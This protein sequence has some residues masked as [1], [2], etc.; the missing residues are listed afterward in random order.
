MNGKVGR[1]K[2]V[3]EG[4]ITVHLEPPCGGTWLKPERMQI[5]EDD[6]FPHQERRDVPGQ[7][8]LLVKAAPRV[9]ARVCHGHRGPDLLGLRYT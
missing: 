8:T 5:A 6:D 9:P 2:K 3:K 4:L 1:V 7:S